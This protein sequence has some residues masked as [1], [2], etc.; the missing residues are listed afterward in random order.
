M[1]ISALIFGVLL[2]GSLAWGGQ[3][4]ASWEGLVGLFT[5]PTAETV[6]DH[7]VL[8]TFSEIRFTESNSV[9]RVEDIWFTG[10]VT[11]IP[12][13]RW[14]AAITWRNESVDQFLENQ[15]GPVASLGESMFTGQLKY[16]LKPVE[17]DRL[18]LAVGVMDVANATEI[19]DGR[20]TN[21][22]RR[23]FLVGSYNW[24]HLGVTYDGH[25]SG[26]YAGARWSIADNLELLGEYVVSPTFVQT[27]PLPENRVNFNIGARFYP[28]EVPDLRF[29]LTAVG[30]SHFNFGFSLSYLL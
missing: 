21:R 15:A 6:T 27:D 25:G 10:S 28:R 13:P 7:R 29:D 14:E 30:N 17:P 22:G 1:R 2:V 4:T 19:I 5:Q 20:Q 3:P 18:G 16:V 11:F 12:A 23:F 26:I 9:D 24:A 8:L